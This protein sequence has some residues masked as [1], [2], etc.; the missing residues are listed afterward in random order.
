MSMIALCQFIILCNDLRKVSL[1]NDV[2]KTNKVNTVTDSA[3]KW[4]STWVETTYNVACCY[5]RRI[6]YW[7]LQVN[8]I[9][10]VTLKPPNWMGKFLIN[11][12]TCLKYIQKLRNLFDHLVEIVF[13]TNICRRH[14]EENEMKICYTSCIFPFHN[15]FRSENKA[16]QQYFTDNNYFYVFFFQRNKLESE[17]GIAWN[18]WYGWWHSQIVR[19]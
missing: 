6:Y 8:P 14:Y 13:S 16:F 19:I 4:S 5:C 12:F 11:N 3:Q 17:T 7:W 1:K 2:R 15:V 10:Y 18:S 9:V